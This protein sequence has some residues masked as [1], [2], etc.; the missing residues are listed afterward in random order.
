MLRSFPQRSHNVCS[1]DRYIEGVRKNKN[2]PLVGK[3]VRTEELRIKS[4]VDH[5]SLGLCFKRRSL[6]VLQ[7]YP[8]D[9]W[10]DLNYA[11]KQF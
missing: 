1:Q 11:K 6:T 4:T 7:M 5:Q 9:T 3:S 8:S 10:H 2:A